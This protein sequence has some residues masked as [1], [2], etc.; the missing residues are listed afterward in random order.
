MKLKVSLAQIKV[1]KAQPQENLQKAEEYISEA[2]K[3]KSEL[4]CFPEMFL[5][6]FNWKF[7]EADKNNFESYIIILSSLAKK[8][9]IWINGSVP[10]LNPNGKISNTSVL[11]ASDGSLAGKYG[12]I[13]LF[14]L[15]KENKYLSPGTEIK[16]V[17]TPWGKAGMSICYDLRF[18]ELFRTCS[19]RGAKIQFLPS[20]WPYPRLEHYKIL[21]KARAIENQNFMIAVNQVGDEKFSDNNTVTYF[22]SS[23]IVD[24]WGNIV[25]EAG[26]KEET[27]LTAE[28]DLD[29]IDEVRKKMT[30]FSDRKPE[31][32][33]PD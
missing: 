12:K 24:P 30:V 4:I 5:T 8:Y 29:V 17:D 26:E 23:V 33:N 16:I 22:G 11:F 2:V 1:A 15:L 14:S 27:L 32:Y 10:E 7:L 25:I 3:K 6:G 28:I 19:L 9:K 31:L 13:H 18:P 20:A 21:I